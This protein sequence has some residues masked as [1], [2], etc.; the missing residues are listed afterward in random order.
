MKECSVALEDVKPPSNL[1]ELLKRKHLPHSAS[2][3]SSLFLTS[4]FLCSVLDFPALVPPGHLQV[5]TQ[6]SAPTVPL[7]WLCS[8]SVASWS[9]SHL[10][11]MFFGAV[12]CSL[13]K[14]LCF[15]PFVHF[16]LVFFLPFWS[17]FLIPPPPNSMLFPHQSFPDSLLTLANFSNSFVFQLPSFLTVYYLETFIE[18]KEYEFSKES[19]YPS[20]HHRENKQSFSIDLTQESIFK[21]IL[22]PFSGLWM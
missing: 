18:E 16:L 20:H 11:L 2:L 17:L 4:P 7:D 12:D 8:F 6:A 15:L 5:C 9:S 22:Q 21:L 13:P 1:P 14:T 3:S 10:S 19:T